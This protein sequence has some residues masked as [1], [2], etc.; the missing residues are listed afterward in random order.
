MWRSFVFRFGDML[1]CIF[2]QH[3]PLSVPLSS[4]LQEFSFGQGTFSANEMQTNKKIRSKQ[5]KQKG[6]YCFVQ[7][8]CYSS[9]RHGWIQVAKRY[10]QESLFLTL[11]IFFPKLTPARAHLWF[12]LCYFNSQVCSFPSGEEAGQLHLQVMMPKLR[13]DDR[14]PLS[15]CIGSPPVLSGHWWHCIW[16]SIYSRYLKGAEMCVFRNLEIHSKHVI[17][18]MLKWGV[19]SSGAQ[20]GLPF[21]TLGL[22]E[23]LTPYTTHFHDSG[24]NKIQRAHRALKKTVRMN[25]FM[26]TTFQLFGLKK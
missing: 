20:T 10:H 22:R 18:K 13:E 2:S 12:L 14:D 6:T 17:K 7:L 26:K 11:F 21:F 24:E 25:T 4:Q 3:R 16:P 1:K 15:S 8:K 19:G 5:L 23:H 9:F